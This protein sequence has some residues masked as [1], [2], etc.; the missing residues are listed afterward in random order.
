MYDPDRAQAVTKQGYIDSWVAFQADVASRREEAML[1][2][3]DGLRILTETITSPTLTAAF[4][5]ILKELPGAKW[6]Q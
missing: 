6:H 5:A 2:N 3:G 4:N 1:K